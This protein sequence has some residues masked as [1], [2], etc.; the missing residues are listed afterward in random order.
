[1]ALTGMEEAVAFKFTR[2]CTLFKTLGPHIF[3]MGSFCSW[4]LQ[5]HNFSLPCIEGQAHVYTY[6]GQRA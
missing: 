4:L 3:Q 1:M 2:V 6:K 5:N